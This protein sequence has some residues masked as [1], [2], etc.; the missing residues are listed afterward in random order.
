M[1]R[2]L[3]SGGTCFWPWRGEFSTFSHFYRPQR[4]CGKVMFSQASVILFTGVCVWQTP[5]WADTPPPGRQPLGR[6][7]PADTPPPSRRL[8][9]WT[10]R[11]LLECILVQTSTT[12]SSYEVE[13]SLPEVE[14]STPNETHFLNVWSQTA[15]HLVRTNRDATR[16]VP[17]VEANKTNNI[18]CSS[19]SP[20]YK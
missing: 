17:A 7:L 2:V 14:T 3:D 12:M 11:I 1:D 19:K 13:I 18:I 16:P 10:V 6:H 5:P 4:S 20:Q 9:Q 15:M 8:L